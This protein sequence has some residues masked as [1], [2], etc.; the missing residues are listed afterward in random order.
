MVKRYIKMVEEHLRN[1]VALYQM[2]FDARLP[3][4]LLAYSPSTHDTM[5]LTLA[6]LVFRRE[7]R[8]R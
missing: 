7:L 6:S 1:V 8:L 2:D 3:I 5:G 4:F